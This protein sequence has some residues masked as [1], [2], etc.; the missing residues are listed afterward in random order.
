M[1]PVIESPAQEVHLGGQVSS[2][3]AVNPEDWNRTLIGLRYIP[4]LS[5]SLPLGS[6]WALDLETSVQTRGQAQGGSIP[7]AET[8]SDVDPYRVWLRL[9]S[10]RWELR[11][12]LQK[13]NFGPALL[14]RSLMWFDSIDPRDPLQL[15]DGVYGLLTRY[16][17]PNNA[18]IW[19]WALYGNQDPK[20][21][22]ALGTRK[23]TLEWGGRAQVPVPRGE[24]G[25][26]F[27][28]R[29][30]DLSGF[31]PGFPFMLPDESAPETRA[32]LDSRWDIGIGLWTEGV[33]IHQDSDL[34]PWPYTRSVTLGMDYTLS[35]GNGLH[36]LA[37]HLTISSTDKPLGRG[38]EA[39][40][41]ALSL[42]YPLGLIDRIS[43]MLYYDWKSEVFYRFF[44]WQRTY[45]L[46]SFYIMAFWNPENGS[47]YSTQADRN[48]FSGK[49]LQ[50][51]VVF[52]H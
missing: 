52:N 8:W 29:R 36:V 15:T 16:Y 32:S 40:F 12:G 45:D 21:W 13:I 49:G 11:L 4:E 44:L 30:F 24:V 26:S 25:V 20:G 46:W 51:M 33:L 42:D 6:S 7:D 38:E 1:I 3:V 39:S 19:A 23:R 27:H 2:W 48:P 22:E 14:L 37:E 5:V 18:N 43:G 50:V 34:L 28:R 10:S 31:S 35:L 41:S 17:F 47:I 9:A